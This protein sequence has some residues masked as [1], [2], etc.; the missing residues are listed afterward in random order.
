MKKYLELL[1][2]IYNCGTSKHPSRAE[3]GKTKNATKGL[4]NLLF[5]HDLSQGFPLLTTRKIAWGACVGELRSFLKGA[6]FTQEFEEN[7]CN[8]WKPW[9]REDGSLGPIYGAQWRKHNQLDH[10]LYCLRD[11][12]TDRRMVVSAWN[13]QENDKMV[14]PPCHLMWVVTSY[15]NKLSL[16]WIQR[17]CDFPIGVPYNIASYALLTH[18]L[19]KW[20]NMEVGN[21][22][23]IF[24][25]AHIYDN[26]REGVTK[27][28]SRI[29]TLLPTIKINFTNDDNFWSWYCELDNYNPQGN[30][31]FGKVEV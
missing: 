19:A 24:C 7:G 29:P 28:L 11:R 25:D 20:G 2:D 9:A 3:S 5:S 26:Q 21:L 22:S 23:C 31:D 18:I 15:S 14:L 13:P 17:S 8:F 30:I 4:S 16:A 27:Q 12:P 10:V 1:E 6:T